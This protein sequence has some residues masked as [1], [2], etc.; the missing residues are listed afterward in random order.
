MKWLVKLADGYSDRGEEVWEAPSLESMLEKVVE[1][2]GP[3]PED[4][5]TAEEYQEAVAD[6]KSYF[7]GDVKKD[8]VTAIMNGGDDVSSL[9]IDQIIDL[10]ADEDNNLVW[11]FNDGTEELHLPA[12]EPQTD[13]P[14][15]EMYDIFDKGLSDK[16]A[17]DD[18]E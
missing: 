12:L 6:L 15:E 4:Y 11:D 14:A 10:E 18:A 3:Q 9:Y 17:E 7:T 1:K 16:P 5:E 8:I 13:D 2:T